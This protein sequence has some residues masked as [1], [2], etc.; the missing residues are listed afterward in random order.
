MTGPSWPGLRPGTRLGTSHVPRGA[1]LY[2]GRPNEERSRKGSPVPPATKTLWLE[3]RS[4]SPG[5]IASR[6]G[7]VSI[8]AAQMRK[9]A[10][11]G[12]PCPRQRRR[13]G[14]RRG[15]QVLERSRPAG[16]ASLLWPP[17]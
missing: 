15:A 16:G 17:K 6:G 14:W 2:Y 11:S 12:V 5:E 8:M 9:E 4:A 13:C 10:G 3:A 1:R 7:R